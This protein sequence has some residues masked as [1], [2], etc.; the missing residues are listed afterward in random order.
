MKIKTLTKLSLATFAALTLAACGSSSSSSEDDL[1]CKDGEKKVEGK[2]VADTPAVKTDAAS[3]AKQAT[4]FEAPLKAFDTAINEVHLSKADK[5]AKIDAAVK[6]YTAV[7][8][9]KASFDKVVAAVKDATAKATLDAFNNNFKA[10]FALNADTVKAA[11]ADESKLSELKT[12]SK[13]VV[14]AIAKLVSGFNALALEPILD[15]ISAAQDYFKAVSAVADEN[16]ADNAAKAVTAYNALK[17][18]MLKA[19]T[20]VNAMEDGIRK[21]AFKTG[22]EN[23][24]KLVPDDKIDDKLKN[25]DDLATLKANATR[26]KTLVEELV[27]QQ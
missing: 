7:T 4:A 11:L 9:A 15:A 1:V 13:L 8:T 24:A 3:L 20:L 25:A 21:T 27:G 12:S 26:L 5:D 16:D 10:F 14:E 6:A 19:S 23:A 2:C 17:A 22:F 18:A